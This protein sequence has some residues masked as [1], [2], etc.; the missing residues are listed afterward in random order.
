MLP[1]KVTESY[2]QLQKE[3]DRSVDKDHDILRRHV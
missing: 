1:C 2:D 3:G